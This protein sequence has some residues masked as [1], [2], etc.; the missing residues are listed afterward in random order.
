MV[1]THLGAREGLHPQ[2]QKCSSVLWLIK[3]IDGWRAARVRSRSPVTET[4]NLDCYNQQDNLIAE[5][6]KSRRVVPN[7][8]EDKY[9]L[10]RACLAT[11]LDYTIAIL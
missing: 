5:M 9:G 8:R 2:N 4:E 3:S 6:K 11:L 7:F 10:A 1:R